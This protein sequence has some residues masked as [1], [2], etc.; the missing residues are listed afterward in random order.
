MLWKT[1]LDLDDKLLSEEEMDHPARKDFQK[2]IWEYMLPLVSSEGPDFL[3]FLMTKPMGYTSMDHPFFQKRF[4][5]VTFKLPS[6]RLSENQDRD[7]HS[8]N[9]QPDTWDP[10]RYQRVEHSY[11]AKWHEADMRLHHAGRNVAVASQSVEHITGAI[12]TILDPTTSANINR[13]QETRD[14]RR[15]E[16][17]EMDETVLVTIQEQMETLQMFDDTISKNQPVLELIQ[18]AI[19]TYHQWYK[20]HIHEEDVV[21]T[22]SMMVRLRQLLRCRSQRRFE[23]VKTIYLYSLWDKI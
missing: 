23:E 7:G 3:R 20:A 11:Q 9:N 10:R 18:K 6:K 8:S 4:P 19:D 2:Q 15:Y 22:A 14:W 16:G 21:R 17:R 12:N 1:A 13:T 5:G